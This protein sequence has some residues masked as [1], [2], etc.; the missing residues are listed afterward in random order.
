VV[1][2]L[3]AR[4]AL[5]AEPPA[6]ERGV[7]IPLDPHDAVPFDVEEGTAAA[8]THAARTP[9]DLR[10]RF[11]SCRC[12]SNALHE[13]ATHLAIRPDSNTAASLSSKRSD[14]PADAAL[15]ALVVRLCDTG[16]SL[17]R[18]RAVGGVV[19]MKE[20][21]SDMSQLWLDRTLVCRMRISL[22][23][24]EMRDEGWRSQRRCRVPRD[25]RGTSS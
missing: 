2:G 9:N 3:D 17:C 10:H 24:A 18:S 4:D 1:E 15:L 7:R 6:I 16:S 11:S 8:M 20:Y 13:H 14:D 25:D 21:G 12:A 5:R 22:D 23:R 19:Q